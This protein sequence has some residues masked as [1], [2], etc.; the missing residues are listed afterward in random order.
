MTIYNYQHYTIFQAL[1]D[2]AGVFQMFM[3]GFGFFLAPY[4]AYSFN[5]WLARKL[6]FVATDDD[7]TFPRTVDASVRS[8]KLNEFSHELIEQ[9]ELEV[10]RH[11]LMR[12]KPWRLFCF[13]FSQLFCCRGCCG[14]RS[15]IMQNLKS[16]V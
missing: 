14:R 9:E 4:A 15:G 11:R 7:L 5:M 1:L 16:G 10:R 12:L 2:L 13:Y 8:S 6:Y 3:F